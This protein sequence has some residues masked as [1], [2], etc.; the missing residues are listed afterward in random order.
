M[1]ALRGFSKKLSFSSF[2][3]IVEIKYTLIVK[4]PAK[5]Q[6]YYV[7]NGGFTLYLGIDKLFIHTHGVKLADRAEF[8]VALVSMLMGLQFFLTGFIAELVSR[9]SSSRNNYLVEEKTGWK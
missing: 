3:K 5:N 8:Y 9:S 4:E 1:E 7:L 2:G 6:V